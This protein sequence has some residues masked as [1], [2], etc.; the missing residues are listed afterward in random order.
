MARADDPTEA[1]TPLN[2]A[3]LLTAAT[4]QS[5][6]G[7]SNDHTVNEALLHLTNGKARIETGSYVGTGTSDESGASSITFSF[8]PKV[9]Q[10]LCYKNGSIYYWPG[11]SSVT[12]VP[13]FELDTTY[14]RNLGFYNSSQTAMNTNVR[15]KK[16]ADG[17]TLYWYTTDSA[18]AQCN[19]EGYIYYWIAIG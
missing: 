3:T 7:D 12:S 15:A 18:G 17:K 16:S 10:L 5:I 19:T 2:T 6:F 4:A 9:V 8:A 14:K 1:G 11:I 13:L